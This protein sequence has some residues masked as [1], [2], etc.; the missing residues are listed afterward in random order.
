MIVAICQAKNNGVTDD[1][2]FADR[3]P[4]P[5]GLAKTL[6]ALSAKVCFLVNP[7]EGIEEG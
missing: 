1:E 2:V 5:S 4:S 3:H 6:E 7:F